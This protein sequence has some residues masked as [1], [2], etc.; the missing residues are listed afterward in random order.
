MPTFSEVFGRNSRFHYK[1]YENRSAQSDVEG[2]IVAIFDGCGLDIEKYLSE[3]QT[4]KQF[5][6]FL[7][8]AGNHPLT[9][10]VYGLEDAK[11]SDS[12]RAP[13]PEYGLFAII[14]ELIRL[15]LWHVKVA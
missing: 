5:E 14:Q 11:S 8:Y 15:D 7:K 10:L 6:D 9:V 13:F 4:K 1:S 12:P 3:D 2:R